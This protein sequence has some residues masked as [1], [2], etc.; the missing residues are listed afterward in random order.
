MQ[1]QVA[2]YVVETPERT[3]VL[4]RSTGLENRHTCGLVQE[5]QRVLHRPARFAGILPADY[6]T[7]CTQ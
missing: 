7:L 4:T 6:D 2:S 1:R 3:L 5:W